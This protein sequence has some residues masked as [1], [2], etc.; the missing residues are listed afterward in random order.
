MDAGEVLRSAPERVA[1]E[2]RRIARLADAWRGFETLDDLGV[3]GVLIPELEEGRGLE[4][5]P[6]HHK[7]VLGHTLEVVRHV[8]EIRADASGDLPV[9]GTAGSRRRWTNRWRT[10]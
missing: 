10:G 2:L 9:V 7:D 1:D 5:T 6:Y 4:Q 3:L 8:C